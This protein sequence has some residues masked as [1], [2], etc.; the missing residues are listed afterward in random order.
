[1]RLLVTGASGQ[2]GA[3]L[4]YESRRDAENVYVWS[5]SSL[6]QRFGTILKPVDLTC[7][8]EVVTAFQK[9]RPD[10]IVHMAAA[11]T[12]A[13][14]HADPQR[15]R[16][17][18]VEGTRMLVKLARRAECRLI[19]ISTDLVFDGEKAPYT[20]SEPA[21]AISVYGQTKVAAEQITAQH[22][23]H[24]IVRISLLFGPSLIHRPSFFDKQVEA[25]RTRTNLQLFE[26]EWRTPLSFVSAA[27]AILQ[28]A[29]SD[30]RGLLH[31]GGP[32]RMSRFEMGLRI[33][34]SL[35]LDPSIFIPVA[36]SQIA[37]AE[38]RPR[39]VSLNSNC[40]RGEFPTADWPDWKSAFAKFSTLH[41]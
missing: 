18:N 30:Y 1:M 37:S 17:V 33:A 3:Y 14:C 22:P 16:T 21:R 7:N 29:T 5:S 4:L 27:K 8:K 25:L 39:D 10:V 35:G 9:I 20:E 15:A 23:N 38:P 6:G 41:D 40:W 12:P 13:K 34:N 36:R 32:E 26:D 11:S 2:L 24:A 31:V 28:I 19:T